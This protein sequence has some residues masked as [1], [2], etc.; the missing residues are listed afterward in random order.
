M[1]LSCDCGDFNEGDYDR[2]W[3]APADYTE[4]P[5]RK[6]RAKCLSCKKPIDTGAIV[7]EFERLRQ[8][9]GFEYETLG[10]EEGVHLASS[11]MCEECTD[12]FFSLTELGFCMDIDS[13]SMQSYLREYH[14]DYAPLKLEHA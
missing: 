5:A 8:P 11:W 2:W 3:Y 7:G 6:R 10:W 13:G 14:R 9:T 1:G 4:M 12:I